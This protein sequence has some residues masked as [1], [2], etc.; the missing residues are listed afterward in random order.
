MREHEVPTH[1]QAE[2]KVLLWLTFP[3]VV[4]VTAVCAIAYGAYRYAPVGPTEV[5]L[6]LAVA[7]GVVGMAMVVGRIGG[8]KLPLVAADLLKYWLGARRYAG[9][10]AE[11]GRNEQPAR[12][13]REPGGLLVLVRRL[14]S[15]RLRRRRGRAKPGT[16][17]RNGR[18]P[19]RPH[20]W[21]RRNRM[22]KEGG[23]GSGRKAAATR[24]GRTWRR[25]LL[26]SLLTVT[27][28]IATVPQAAL[29]D[30]HG[31]QRLDGIEFEVP[32]PV[33][34]RRVYVEGLEVSD[35]RAHVTLRAATAVHLRTRGYGGPEGRTLRFWGSKELEEGER[36]EYGMPLSG[37]VHSL[38]FAW[39]DALGQAGALSLKDEELPYPL[40]QVDGELCDVRI[41]SLGWS[42]GTID[43]T[44]DSDC[45]LSVEERVEL[46]VIAGHRDETVV[47]VLEAEVEAVTG[48]VE[49]AVGG[50]VVSVPFV[51][52]GE[53]AF[54]IPVGEGRTV[55]GVALEADLQADLEVPMPPLVELT[56][57][58]AWTEERT[59]T[60]TVWRPG[61]SRTVTRTVTVTHEDGT[62]TE[63]EI[64]ARL[65]L[66][67]SYVDVDVTLTVAHPERVLVEV[68]ERAPR[69][70]SRDEIL[71]LAASIAA[72]DPFAVLVV[73][74]R[75]EEPE[76]GRQTRVDDDEVR[77]LFGL[78]DGW[79]WPS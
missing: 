48:T 3:Q 55:H 52:D 71:E 72:D 16:E 23:Q 25:A 11:L 38:T 76:P 33:P 8:R 42:P 66:P 53:T 13:V 15:R 24:R 10:A 26:A 65:S 78:L 36:I 68:V 41:T 22:R 6:G 29:A 51:Q 47:A 5:R 75:E 67:G 60:V 49:V 12:P 17:K 9:T 54:E 32:E 45:V 43:G 73:P 14:K 18:R 1:V 39:E 77:D 69:R 4:A 37:A 2:D 63:H 62:E 64:S 58:A 20:G 40:P 30:E 56:R 61:R 74:E 21:F 35:D 70:G 44:L 28:G 7:V 34:G 19:F 57:R 27:L 79:A 31:G 50:E 46:A 59:R